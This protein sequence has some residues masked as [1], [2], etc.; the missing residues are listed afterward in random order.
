MRDHDDSDRTSNSAFTS[1]RLARRM[2]RANRAGAMRQLGVSGE[3]ADMLQAFSLAQLRKLAASN[4]AL[5]SFR[6]VALPVA[7]FGGASGAADRTQRNANV[8]TP[9]RARPR[10]TSQHASNAWAGRFL[11]GFAAAG[12]VVQAAVL[13]MTLAPSLA[14]GCQPLATFGGA[15]MGLLAVATMWCWWRTA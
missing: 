10:P 15:A 11:R 7:A 2:L 5:C 3:L 8:R 12:L 13:A 1:L 6:L 4:F 14:P 9:A